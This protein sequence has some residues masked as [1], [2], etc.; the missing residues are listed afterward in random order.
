MTHF[1]SGICSYNRRITGAILFE[2]RPAMII[3]S[4]WRGDPRITSAPKRE[5]SNRDPIMDLI[6]QAPHSTPYHSGQIEFF[7]AQLI[8]FPTVVVIIPS[9]V[10]A[11]SSLSIRA[12]NSGGRLISNLLSTST[13]LVSHGSKM[14]HA[15]DNIAEASALTRA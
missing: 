4:D 10:P 12:N 2:T 7:L 11:V 9:A 8:A 15:H 13:S 3:R 5:I 14:I 1:G 6:S